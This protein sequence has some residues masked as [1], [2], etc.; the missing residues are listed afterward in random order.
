MNPELE[1]LLQQKIEELKQ[2]AKEYAKQLYGDISSF[3]MIKLEEQIIY[4][5]GGEKERV[6]ELYVDT[7]KGDFRVKKSY[8]LPSDE[9]DDK[10]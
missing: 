8:P 6:I 10:I 9:N 1:K 7:D 3:D 2:I 4:H 5:F